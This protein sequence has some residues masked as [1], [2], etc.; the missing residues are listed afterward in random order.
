V[1]PGTWRVY[2]FDESA[3]PWYT[4]EQKAGI[5]ALLNVEGD[6]AET[7]WRRI[8]LAAHHYEGDSK[9][10]DEV[11]R[12]KAI[13]GQLGDIQK[14]CESLFDLLGRAMHQDTYMALLQAGARGE[15]GREIDELRQL[16]RRWQILAMRAADS[17]P[18]P[19]KPRKRALPFYVNELLRI[20]IDNG[21]SLSW[22][23][24]REEDYS[25]EVGQY[26]EYPATG[27]V[28]DFVQ[29]C[30]GPVLNEKKQKRAIEFLRHKALP[31]ARRAK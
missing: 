11:A 24:H 16:A 20:G 31:A 21:M 6:T 28:P 22:A 27:P 17:Q 15:A 10:E 23:W 18:K 13:T 30:T 12:Q 19:T 5:L 14:A 25:P 1:K 29:A 3:D 2:G 9:V 8:L 4:P 7:A 26:T